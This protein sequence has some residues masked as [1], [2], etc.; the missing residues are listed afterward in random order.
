MHPQKYRWWPFLHYPKSSLACFLTVCLPIWWATMQY[1]SDTDTASFLE[2][3]A[4][5]AKLFEKAENL[6]GRDTILIVDLECP[7]VFSISCIGTLADLGDAFASRPEVRYTK[8]LAHS[9][10]PI[11]VGLGFEFRP[12]IPPGPL[13]TEQLQEIREFS[14]N[15]PFVRDILVSAD[16]RHALLTVHYREEIANGWS[17]EDF[18]TEVEAVLGPFREKGH[19]I[20]ALALPL[21]ATEMRVSI[22]RD[23]SIFAPAAILI[24]AVVFG[25]AFRS[26]RAVLYILLSEALLASIGPAFFRIFDQS[27]GAFG[28]LILPLLSC[29]QLAL[30]THVCGAFLAA[31]RSGQHC[32]KASRSMLAGIL[33][34]CTFA[35]LTTASGL[36]ALMASPISSV[37]EFGLIGSLGV[38]LV[39]ILTFGPGIALLQVFFSPP[40]NNST[41]TPIAAA[42]AGTLTWDRFAG[43]IIRFRLQVIATAVLLLAAGVPGIN[44]IRADLRISE[45]FD[46]ASGT[47]RALEVIDSNYGGYQFIQLEVDSG[48]ESGA[49]SLSFLQE[50]QKLEI[51]V[52]SQPGV[53]ATFSY[54]RIFAVMNQIWAGGDGEA[55]HLTD[56]PLLQNVFNLALATQDLPL[57]DLLGDPAKRV[58]NMYIRVPD[59]SRDEFLDILRNT[60]AFASRELPPSIRVSATEGIHTLLQADLRV[61]NSQRISFLC[62]LGAVGFLLAVLWRS[63]PLALL[64][65]AV[66]VLPLLS[67]FGLTG[68]LGVPANSLTAMVGA[69]VLGIAVDDAVHFITCWHQQGGGRSRSPDALTAAFRVKGTPILVS[70]IILVAI[71]L[72]F[73][74]SSFPPVRTFGVLAAFGFAV[75][76][77]TVLLVLPAS[78]SMFP[79]SWIKRRPSPSPPRSQGQ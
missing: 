6:I 15:H 68:Y 61:I 28:F 73:S 54:S 78:L 40:P 77:V 13:G 26:F 75:T 30:L 53:A 12:F 43:W 19:P 18:Q 70:T 66:T 10:L 58:A 21:V 4:H 69:I 63:L 64:A 48:K 60:L 49:V 79:D 47:R 55:L 45:L 27:G 1:R 16:G 22:L 56:S 31:Y 5:S 7:E 52:E 62:T 25:I 23:F 33:Q 29:I 51:F 17:N 65:V 32:A 39:F 72:L 71:F 59:K 50:L 57:L 41:S 8:S 36:A 37:R 14:I 2:G 74:I 44:A 76:G 46:D 34:S 20:H 3:D 38:G 35:S 42:T 11:R 67:A 24:T 9:V